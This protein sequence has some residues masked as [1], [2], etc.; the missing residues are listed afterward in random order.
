MSLSD[1]KMDGFGIY[2]YASGDV[3]EGDYRAGQMC[4]RGE[5]SSTLRAASS[6]MHVG[7]TI[8][9]SPPSTAGVYK[10]A[11]GDIYEGEMQND[12]RHGKGVL[13][14]RDGSVYEGDFRGSVD[15]LYC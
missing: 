7:N 9:P 4:G 8:T 13:F 6:I 15:I 1:D 10:C 12:R 5:D 2:N 11:S 14:F 3:F